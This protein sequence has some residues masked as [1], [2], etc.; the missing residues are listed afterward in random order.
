MLISA[1][2]RGA[3]GTRSF[4]RMLQY[5]VTGAMHEAFV[6]VP[7]R[8]SHPPLIEELAQLSPANFLSRPGLWV[9]LAFAAACLIAAVRLR[10][11]REPI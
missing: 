8:G 6:S 10:R 4:M 1:F 7:R 11:S 3:F 5:R 9:G 2:E